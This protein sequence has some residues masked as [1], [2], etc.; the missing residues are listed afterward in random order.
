[1]PYSRLLNVLDEFHRESLAI[2]V[3]LSLPAERVARVLDRLIAERGRP[4]ELWVDNGPEFTSKVLDRWAAEHGVELRFIRPGKP[5]ETGRPARR[6]PGPRCCGK[7]RGPW[8]S[9]AADSSA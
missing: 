5:V 4:R 7:Q 6:T 3:D 8:S 2:E 1:M 9:A